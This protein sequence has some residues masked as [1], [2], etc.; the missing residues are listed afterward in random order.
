M[1]RFIKTSLSASTVAIVACGLL[2][3]IAIAQPLEEVTVQ[4]KRLITTKLVRGT[5]SLGV[6]IL[7]ISVSYGVSTAGLDLKS[8]EGMEAME[9]RVNDAAVAACEQIQRDYPDA[10]PDKATCAKEAAGKAMSQVHKLAHAGS[11]NPAG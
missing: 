5:S 7:D 2:T 1:R 6:P 4:A 9:K 11:T 3:S 8:H 10:T